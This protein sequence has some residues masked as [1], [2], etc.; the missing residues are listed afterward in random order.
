MKHLL[1]NTFFTSEEDL[2]FFIDSKGWDVCNLTDYH[3]VIE[4]ENEDMEIYHLVIANNTIGVYFYEG[5]YEDYID[6]RI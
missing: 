6:C 4:N 3:L 5:Y 1:D 2:I